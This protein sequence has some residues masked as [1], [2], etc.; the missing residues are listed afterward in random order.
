M[1]KTSKGKFIGAGAVVVV[2]ALV[3]A[4][5]LS[6]RSASAA[7]VSA[8]SPDTLTLA[9]TDITQRLSVS[10]VVKSAA[11]ANIYSTQSYPVKEILAEVGDTVKTGDILAVLDM[12]KLDNDIAQAEINYLSALQNAEEDQRNNTNSVA[13]AVNSLEASQISLSKQQLSTSN[14][15]QDLQEAIEKLSEPF[16]SLTYDRAIEDARI[17]LERKQADLRTAEDDLLEAQTDFDGY[18]Y[19]NAITEAE[20]TLKRKQNDKTVAKK[21][22]SDAKRDAEDSNDATVKSAQK[23]YD[24]AILAVEDAQRTLDKAVTDLERAQND[25]VSQ[26]EDQAIKAR[27]AAEDASRTYEKALTDKQRAIEDYNDANQTQLTNAQKTVADSQK[28][29]QSSQNSLQSARESYKQVSEK[30]AASQSNIELQKLNLDKLYTQREEGIITATMDGV[31]TEANITVGATPS[32]ILFVIEDTGDLYVSARIKEYNLAS[33]ALGQ[34]V[35]VTSDATGDRLY[36]GVI[37]YISPKAVSEAGS[38]SVEFEIRAAL[39]Q[40]DS[41][42]KIGMNAFVSIITADKP[43]VYAVPL[44]MIVTTA[45]GSFVYAPSDSGNVAIPVTVGFKTSTEAE[46]TGGG[47]YD[48]MELLTDPEGKLGQ[49]G[50]GN[51]F[52]FN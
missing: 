18:S 21:E 51:G 46:I 34:P 28:Q 7:S 30:P 31:I 27:E 42:I 16:D 38:T 44:S 43:N 49:G 5:W 45:E 20:I 4:V 12:S 36:E 17:A 35:T 3:A 37:D 11:T 25:A 33:V 32:G 40:P 41:D 10:G 6:G 15:E 47:L 50:L 19:R 24:N 13:N 1:K 29:L 48:G 52:F 14:A 23:T 39:N 2:V 26:A 22:L 9:K 8:Q